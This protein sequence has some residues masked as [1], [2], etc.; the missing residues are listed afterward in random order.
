MII[1]ERTVVVDTPLERKGVA[2][3]IEPLFRGRFAK[4][5]DEAEAGLR[6]ALVKL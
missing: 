6:N 2:R 5:G 3:L 4:L 1:I